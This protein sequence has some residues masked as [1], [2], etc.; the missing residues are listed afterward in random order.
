M[1]LDVD[2]PGTADVYQDDT[3]ESDD[4]D[5]YEGDGVDSG[6]GVQGEREYHDCLAD[7]TWQDSCR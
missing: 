5:A 2:R 7:Q 3:K 6:D 1:F 4:G